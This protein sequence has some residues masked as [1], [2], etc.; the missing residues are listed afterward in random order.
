MEIPN[1]QSKVTFKNMYEVS[2]MGHDISN[3]LV[4]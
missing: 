3:I 4:L 1:P 2:S